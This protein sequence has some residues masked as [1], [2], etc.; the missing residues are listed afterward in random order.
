MP[1]QLRYSTRKAEL[2]TASS[3]YCDKA[4]DTDGGIWFSF[5]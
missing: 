2:D 4:K 3:K 5:S 1:S